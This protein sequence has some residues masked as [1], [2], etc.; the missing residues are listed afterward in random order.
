MFADLWSRFDVGVER[1]E[2]GISGKRR[3]AVK[4]EVGLGE[5]HWKL[6]SSVG[7]GVLCDIPTRPYLTPLWVKILGILLK[8]VLS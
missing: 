1:R 4:I 3:K 7:A 2:S 8:G 6:S 5:E